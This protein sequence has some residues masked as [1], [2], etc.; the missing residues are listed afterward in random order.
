MTTKN[1]PESSRKRKREVEEVEK[2]RFIRWCND[3][4]VT[5]EERRFA[6]MEPKPPCQLCG[7]RQHG[8]T[9]K[10][11]VNGRTYGNLFVCPITEREITEDIP[12]TMS[13]SFMRFDINLYKMAESIHFDLHRLPQTI[14]DYET[15]GEGRFKSPETIQLIRERLRNICDTYINSEPVKTKI[16]K[17]IDD[18]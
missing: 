6:K 3:R 18:L 10:E 7:S 16:G 17:H 12:D 4:C 2:E 5:M 14:L 1:K 11:S 8:V 13:P 9:M 15:Y